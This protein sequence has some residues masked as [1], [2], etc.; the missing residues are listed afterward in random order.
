ML[1][2]HLAGAKSFFYEGSAHVPMAVRL[3]RSWDDR[4]PGT[5]VRTPVSLAD[6]MPTII[7][8]AGGGCGDG[9]DGLDL[10]EIARGR[11]PEGP[12]YAECTSDAGGPPAFWGITDGRWKYIWYPEGAREQLFDLE[13]DPREEKDLAAGGAHAAKLAELRD[14]VVRRLSGRGHPLVADGELVTRPVLEL[15]GPAHRATGWMGYHTD[16]CDLDVRH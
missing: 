1:G 10:A 14:E 3:P 15:D 12:R 11:A 16:R 6:V 2:D 9:V 13:T 7:A 5:V 8:A 4:R